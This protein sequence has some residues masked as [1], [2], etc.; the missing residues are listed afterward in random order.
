MYKIVNLETFFIP[1]DQKYALL[2]EE[3][4]S[5]TKVLGLMLADGYIH[6]N[7]GELIKQI[8]NEVDLTIVAGLAGDHTEY[9]K[10]VCF[11]FNLH[12]TYL[13]YRDQQTHKWNNESSRFLFLGGVPSRPNRS[14]LLNKYRRS[15]MLDRCL[16][17]FF[18]PWTDQQDSWCKEYLR[19]DYIPTMELEQSVDSVYYS[20]RH[21]GTEPSSNEWTK[22]TAWID[23][24][25]FQQTVL[26]IVSEG[27]DGSDI[28]SRYLTEKTYR[29]FVQR[30][31]F[32]H[33]SNAEM[34]DHMKS[35]DFKTFE[36]YMLIKDYAYLE[37]EEDR[38]N[39]IV[40]NTKYFL[41][42]HHLYN[43]KIQQDIEYNYNRF[44]ELAETNAKILETLV[45]DYQITQEDIDR[46]FNQTG[47]NHLVRAYGN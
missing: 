4:G 12:T 31:P 19:D 23:P 39:A 45:N 25:I 26:S 17:T 3:I 8:A 43:E 27:I 46:W 38:L 40:E 6:Q 37:S 7:P 14:G 28:S 1:E 16:W 24:S 20:S 5:A 36:D 35:L 11:D 10:T 44:F 9:S 32:L 30:H 21:Y 22:N 41:S 42:N 18:K 2:K 47:W 13:S 34:F 29:V 15:D 33:A